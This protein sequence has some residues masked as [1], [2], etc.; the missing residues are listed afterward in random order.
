MYLNLKSNQI[1]KT[2]IFLCIKRNH[3]GF[4]MFSEIITMASIQKINSSGQQQQ[5]EQ[6]CFH[7]YELKMD[8]I[9]FYH[10]AYYKCSIKFEWQSIEYDDRKLPHTIAQRSAFAFFIFIF[11]KKSKPEK[12][13]IDS[14]YE[15]EKNHINFQLHAKL[16]YFAWLQSQPFHLNRHNNT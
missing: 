12:L 3:F 5:L 14:E 4:S 7:L 1:K 11:F 8:G 16:I 2:K 9:L 13:N 6:F 10:W 15:E